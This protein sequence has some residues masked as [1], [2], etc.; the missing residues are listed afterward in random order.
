MS[1][2]RCWILSR[3]TFSIRPTLSFGQT[4]FAGLIRKWREWWWEERRDKR[5]LGLTLERDPNR[6]KS[7]WGFPNWR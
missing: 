1:I 6:L 4:A 7:E 5:V 2:A 3:A